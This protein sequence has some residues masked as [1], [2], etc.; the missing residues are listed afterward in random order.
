MAIEPA[1]PGLQGERALFDD[2]PVGLYRTAVDGIILD[3]NAALAA[4]LGL[5]DVGYLLGR[6]IGELFADPTA[7]ARWR[8]QLEREGGAHRFGFLGRRSDGALIWLETTTR[9]VRD[10]AGAVQCHV[11]SLEDVTARERVQERRRQLGEQRQRSLKMEAVGRLAAGVAHDFGN[12]LTVVSGRAELLLMS[13]DD[14][15]P[16]RE[17]AVEILRAA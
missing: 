11:G 13:F 1:G 8:E 17:H 6:N 4:L 3:G 14:A 5:A 15:D 9:A 7:R 2:V 10:E 16:R 12:L